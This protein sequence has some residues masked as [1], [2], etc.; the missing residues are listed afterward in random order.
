MTYV[1][2]YDPANVP[3]VVQSFTS[4]A[5]R[6]SDA[7]DVRYDLIS[8]IALEALARTCAEGAAKYSDFNWEKGMPVHDIL[9]HALRHIYKFL[10][11]D[12]SEE[13]LAHAMWNLG[14][15]IHSIE[16]WPELNEGHLR[17]EGCLPPVEAAR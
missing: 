17:R 4:G 12:R 6:S 14:A 11:G 5:V 16:L 10:G 7:K 1:P 13:H 15:A 2:E 9:N 3:L 8:P